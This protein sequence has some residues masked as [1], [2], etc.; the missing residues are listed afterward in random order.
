MN[1]VPDKA[2]I[3]EVALELGIDPAF[4]EKDWYVVQIIK[5][6]TS[7]ESL[8]AQ[9][10]FAGGTAL[11]KAH[12]LLQRFSEDIDFRL[13]LPQDAAATKSRQ[14]KLLSAIRDRLHGMITAHFPLEV[15]KGKSAFLTAMAYSCCVARQIPTLYHTKVLTPNTQLLA[16]AGEQSANDANRLLNIRPGSVRIP[17]FC[18]IVFSY[19][20]SL[21]KEPWLTRDTS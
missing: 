11:S 18:L 6:I 21:R 20:C 15:V 9:V 10:I 8:G 12:R 19:S 13:I 2:A 3:E 17:R 7:M 1:A 5:E 16:P 4:V 14:R